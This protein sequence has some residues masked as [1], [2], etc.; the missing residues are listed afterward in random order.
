MKRLKKNISMIKVLHKAS[1]QEQKMFLGNS[2]LN[3]KSVN[4]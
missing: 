1:P 2:K 3:K 4:S